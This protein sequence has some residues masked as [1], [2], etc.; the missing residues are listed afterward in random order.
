M[1]DTIIACEGVT[2]AYGPE[3]VVRGASFEVRRGTFLPFVGPNGAGKTSLIRAILGLVRPRGGRIRTPFAV[4]PPG[5]V[6]QQK[7]IDPLFPVSVREIVAMGLYP[8][9][10]WWRRLR[11]A[12]RRTVDAA[13]ERF[14]LLEHAGKCFPELSGG[15]KQKALLARAMAADAE[16][17]VFDEPTSELDEDSE[18]EVL[19]HLGRLNR[20]R[21]ATVIMAHHGLDKL[22]GLADRALFFDHGHVRMAGLVAD[23]VGGRASRVD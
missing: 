17:F 4:R 9:L 22:G 8:R 21:D 13:L 2:I 10:G 12:E 20:E 5:Y 7:S 6:P 3:V 11:A 1:S 18:N 23:Q 19:A 16:V 15:M 14:G